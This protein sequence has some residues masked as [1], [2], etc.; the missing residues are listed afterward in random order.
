MKEYQKYEKDIIDVDEVEGTDIKI[1]PDYYIHTAII[2]AQ[3]ALNNP[4]F[5]AGYRQF[6]SIVKNMES[7][8]T[9]SNLLPNDYHDQLKDF[10]LTEEYKKEDNKLVRMFLLSNKKMEIILENVFSS[11]TTSSPLPA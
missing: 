4:D 2:H 1:N 11:K 8:A 7:L 10:L 9:A 6:F 5:N 3:R